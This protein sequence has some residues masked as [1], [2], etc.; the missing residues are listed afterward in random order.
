M[1]V[2]IKSPRG[3]PDI[4]GWILCGPWPLVVLEGVENSVGRVKQRWWWSV[5][6]KQKLPDYRMLT[7]YD[8]AGKIKYLIFKFS[9]ITAVYVK[10]NRILLLCNT[11]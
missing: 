6:E 9:H 2:A 8:W 4:D 3:L 1:I 10:R 11:G 5:G 7:A